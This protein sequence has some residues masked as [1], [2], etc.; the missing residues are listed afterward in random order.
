MK[1]AGGKDAEHLWFGEKQSTVRGGDLGMDGREV[2]GKETAVLLFSIKDEQL[3][4]FTTHP[5][6]T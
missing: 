5:R 1:G 6:R 2:K 4:D 3:Q